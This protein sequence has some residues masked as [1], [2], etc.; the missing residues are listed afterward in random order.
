MRKPKTAKATK[1]EHFNLL[2]HPEPIYTYKT[3]IHGQEVTVKMYPT[4]AKIL[5][6]VKA[7]YHE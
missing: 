1:T 4:D 5:D 6:E 7:G 3:I 2:P